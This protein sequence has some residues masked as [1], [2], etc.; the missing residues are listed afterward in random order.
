MGYL[1]LNVP[2]RDNLVR[3]TASANWFVYKYAVGTTVLSGGQPLNQ[4]PSVRVYERPTWVV[5][6]NPTI[7]R[8]GP[9]S[10]V[11]GIFNIID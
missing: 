3:L 8:L 7:T 6:S 2:Q 4:D 5:K 9:A 10:R 1:Y 11:P